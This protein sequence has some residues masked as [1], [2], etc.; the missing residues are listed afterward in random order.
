MRLR[1]PLDGKNKFYT[2]FYIELEYN[3]DQEF[4]EIE[5]LGQ[6]LK[7]ENLPDGMV[8][9]LVKEIEQFEKERRWS[10]E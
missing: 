4:F 2:R 5:L 7:M 3:E 6:K 9:W 10:L 1:I 8:D